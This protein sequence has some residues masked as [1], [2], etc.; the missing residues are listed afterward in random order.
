MNTK[1]DKGTI[2]SAIIKY[3]LMVLYAIFLIMPVI[4]AFSSAFRPASEIFKYSA[5]F[6]Y[7]TLIPEKLTLESFRSLFFDYNFLKPL[8]NTVSVCLITVVLGILL[9]AMAGFAFAKIDFKGKEW[10]FTLV[11]I[12]MIIPFEAI[13]IP[14][15]SLI[16]NIKL[17]NTRTAL[18]LPAVANGTYIFLFK[19]AYE[20]IPHSLYEAGIVE[21]ASR[22]KVFRS[23]YLP[24]SKPIMVS[25]G[26]LIFFYQW[27]SYMWPL[28]A[29]NAPNV[30]VIQIA[31][32]VFQQEYGTLWG[33]IFASIII[34]IAVPLLFFLPLQK[35]Y[36]IGI[37][38]SGMKE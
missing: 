23:L 34:T 4:Y 8:M 33:E 28:L 32:S 26:L 10:M 37:S 18:I 31:Q 24:L 1:N 11:I 9:N 6:S 13:A 38:T 12:T 7:R 25:A 2:I 21:G 17:V 5:P 20:D 30:Q 15:Y 35:Y 3:L 19:N 22:F 14:L 36:T 27:Q 16:Y 29:A